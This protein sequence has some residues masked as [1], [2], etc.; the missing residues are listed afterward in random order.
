VN[1]KLDIEIRRQLEDSKINQVNYEL[2]QRV[3]RLYATVKGFKT[4]SFMNMMEKFKE[5]NPPI[6]KTNIIMKNV[7][8]KSAHALWL[9]L[10]HYTALGLETT[11]DERNLS[12]ERNYQSDIF[13]LIIMAFVTAQVNDRKR[14]EKYTDI[15]YDKRLIR[16][17]KLRTVENDPAL[18]NGDYWIDTNPLNEYILNDTKI[19]FI[20][21]YKKLLD[22]GKSEAQ[23]SDIILKKILSV[24]NEL[25]KNF[26]SISVDPDDVFTGLA[27]P[28]EIDLDE[29]IEK[30]KDK[31]DIM[32]SAIRIEEQDLEAA[33]KEQDR[34]QKQLDKY[35]KMKLE[36]DERAKVKKEKAEESR[37]KALEVAR[38]KTEIL[39][40]IEE[41]QAKDKE[42]L[43]RIAQKAREAEARRLNEKF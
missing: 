28:K 35:D 7:D 29:Q 14:K 38:L 18:E 22:S 17:P 13:G 42:R 16:R 15:D 43:E 25:Y 8:F 23:A 27:R 3:E 36:K 1:F 19:N 20:E 31:S 34:Y 32:L 26:F 41:Q 33:R 5:V 6:M 21:E 40:Q 30:I 37:K 10:D 2:L 39:K 24:T 12:I 9:F 4:S 11:S